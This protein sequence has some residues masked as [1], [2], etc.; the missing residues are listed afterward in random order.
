MMVT[1]PI[2][3]YELMLRTSRDGRRSGLT[4]I[5]TDVMAMFFWPA[6]MMVSSV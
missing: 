6:W 1:M 3:T 5:G 4:R 2:L